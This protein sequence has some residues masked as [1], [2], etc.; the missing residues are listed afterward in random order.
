VVS[1]DPVGADTVSE[2][3]RH[4]F[5][6]CGWIVGSFV[7]LEFLQT[8]ADILWAEHY[9]LGFVRG[10]MPFVWVAEAIFIGLLVWGMVEKVRETGGRKDAPRQWTSTHFRAR[11][12]L[13]TAAY[14]EIERR[15][16]ENR[17]TMSAQIDV[18]LM[19]AVADTARRAET[20]SS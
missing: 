4:I 2:R 17:R 5:T 6:A 15:A 3:A 11:L 10:Y 9:D 14:C 20:S 18:I 13:P 1:L 8:G 19:D 7:F 16:A 12:E